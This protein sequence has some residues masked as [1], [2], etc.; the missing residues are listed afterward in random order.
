MSALGFSSCQSVHMTGLWIDMAAASTI[1]QRLA[2]DTEIKLLTFLC[3]ST[4]APPTYLAPT[5]S[6]AVSKRNKEGLSADIT[7]TSVRGDDV[8]D[9]DVAP[10]S[11][12][13]ARLFPSLPFTCESLGPVVSHHTDARKF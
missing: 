12:V 10:H 11:H 13:S 2:L 8:L 6:C 4:F 5:A 1:T 9:C 7:N 3:F